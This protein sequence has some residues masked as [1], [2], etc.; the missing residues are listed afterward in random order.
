MK[1]LRNFTQQLRFIYIDWSLEK[2][3]ALCPCIFLLMIVAKSGVVAI[4]LLL[5][6]CFDPF[7]K[8]C[9]LNC[10]INCRFELQQFAQDLFSAGQSVSEN[11]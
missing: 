5:L 9:R 2:K 1:S 11:H 8:C 6:L 7:V 10:R 3:D 4:D